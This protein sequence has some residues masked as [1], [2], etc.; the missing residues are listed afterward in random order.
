MAGKYVLASTETTTLGE[1]LDHWSE[2]TGKETEYLQITLE[3]YARLWPMWGT[4]V[5]LDLQ[6]LDDLGAES[7]S[8]EKWIGK[9]ELGLGPELVGLREA[10]VTLV[11]KQ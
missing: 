10:L 4:E 5:G 2:I 8:G 9:E 6:C 7:W 3:E 11:G 1:F